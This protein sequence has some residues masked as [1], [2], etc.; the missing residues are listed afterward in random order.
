MREFLFDM[1]SN[2]KQLQFCIVKNCQLFIETPEGAE[3][4]GYDKSSSAANITTCS[5]CT[6]LIGDRWHSLPEQGPVG[7]SVG[8]R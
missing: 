3:S 5:Y 4:H 2:Q 8:A 6:V 1:R 7:G